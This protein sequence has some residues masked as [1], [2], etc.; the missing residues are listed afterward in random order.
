MI[1][2][3]ATQGL[4]LQDLF[5]ACTHQVSG[6]PHTPSVILLE[7]RLFC[8]KKVKSCLRFS[9]A[10]P[11]TRFRPPHYTTISTPTAF[12]PSPKRV[13][14]CCVPFYRCFQ[15]AWNHRGESQLP[16]CS[17]HAATMGADRTVHI[18]VGPKQE[19]R[20]QRGTGSTTA[21][22]TPVVGWLRMPS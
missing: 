1:S 14:V 22:P 5:T 17:P 4:S 9:R 3:C 21:A 18:L 2:T 11:T 15:S 20:K 16:Q 8:V 6:F 7:T 10:T 19:G 12:T 13:P